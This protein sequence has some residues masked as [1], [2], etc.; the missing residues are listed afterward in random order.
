MVIL[1]VTLNLAI[2]KTYAVDHFAL[3]QVNRTRKINGLPGGKG[4]NVARV[5]S[6]FG[7]EVV[8]TGFVGGYNGKYIVKNLKEQ[9]FTC[10]FQEISEESRLCI[11]ILSDHSSTEILEHGP[12]I[13]QEEL[14]AFLEKFDSLS[15][16]AKV[17]A[18]SGSVPR[19]VTH[20][21]YKQMIEIADKNG[22]YTILDSSGNPFTE[23]LKG[24]PYMAK[25]NK[26]ELEEVMEYS[27][28]TNAKIYASIQQYLN[29]G[30]QLFVLSMGSRGALVG[31]NG[32][33]FKVS[34]PIVDAINPVGCGDALVA[35]FAIG[36]SREMKIKEMI[37]LATATAASNALHHGAGIIQKAEVDNLIKQVEVNK[38]I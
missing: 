37:K 26:E 25:P 9:L 24:K 31:Y 4:I 5:A 21:I 17:V 29:D 6:A 19:G 28:D 20:T 30:I 33:I 16:K 11:N 2:D 10:D 34:P 13:R 3:S 22:A 27:L 23:G 8:A 12:H 1:T 14:A 38:L 7:E 15:R 32:E 35:G 18:M 36:I